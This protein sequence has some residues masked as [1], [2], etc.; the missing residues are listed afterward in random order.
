MTDL[1]GSYSGLS[2]VD[3]ATLEFLALADDGTVLAHDIA[4]EVGVAPRSMG[5]RMK[6]LAARG[7]VAGHY[8]PELRL[9]GWAL[10]ELGATALDALAG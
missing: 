9:N 10:T 6:S 2:G 3:I 8:Q 4:V 1:H 7:L 5:A